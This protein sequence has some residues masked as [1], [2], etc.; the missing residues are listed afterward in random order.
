MIP[1]PVDLSSCRFHAEL[2]GAL[3]YWELRVTLNGQRRIF[4]GKEAT[5]TQCAE[6]ATARMTG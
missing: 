3:Y 5:L 2:Y 1:Q 4:D 6:A